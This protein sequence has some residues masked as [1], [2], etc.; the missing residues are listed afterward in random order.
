MRWEATRKAPLA[1]PWRRPQR[2]S[3]QTLGG[4]LRRLLSQSLGDDLDGSNRK[5]S[6]VTRSV[7]AFARKPS[8][9]TRRGAGQ[10]TRSDA[11]AA[12]ANTT[13]PTGFV[14]CLEIAIRVTPTRIR[15]ALS[16]LPDG[17][18]GEGV[19][20]PAEGVWLPQAIQHTIYSARALRR[21]GLCYCPAPHARTGR[22]YV[23]CHLQSLQGVTRL[24]A[25]PLP[26]S[27]RRHTAKVFKA[28]LGCCRDSVPG[29][30]WAWAPDLRAWAL[31]AAKRQC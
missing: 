27:S 23:D 16:E 13:S 1:G 31:S 4:R 30:C 12:A 28:S 22:T 29:A 6:D 21:A 3:S 5:L 7:R 15:V 18:A 8:E 17:A 24:K 10:L 11:A 9:A 19:G 2:L 14:V 26:K 25:S 20:E